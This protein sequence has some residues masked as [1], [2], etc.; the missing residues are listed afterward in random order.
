[1]LKTDLVT[2]L[3]VLVISYSILDGDPKKLQDL[4]LFCIANFH[5]AQKLGK[6]VS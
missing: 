4:V 1:M 6:A 3:S 2:S 5:S